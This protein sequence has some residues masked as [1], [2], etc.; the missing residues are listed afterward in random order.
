[1]EFNE[2]K[3]DWSIY[4]S[5]ETTEAFWGVSLQF[6][7]VIE[8]LNYIEWTENR[9]Q[10]LSRYIKM[11]GL[12]LS[13]TVRHIRMDS[14]PWEELC[15]YHLQHHSSY[16]TEMSSRLSDRYPTVLTN[17]FCIYL[18]I[19]YMPHE[20][21][22]LLNTHLSGCNLVKLQCIGM[23]CSFQYLQN[24]AVQRLKRQNAS[25]Q[26]EI[27]RDGSC[28]QTESFSTL[29][30]PQEQL[31]CNCFHVRVM[32]FRDYG[33]MT[34]IYAHIYTGTTGCKS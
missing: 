1:M 4:R 18:R 19:H 32:T 16:G 15:L 21:A 8:R 9:P 6:Q 20:K 17:A 24:Y 23:L 10:K 7:A 34:L 12:Y 14:N 31:N 2:K 5:M 27:E 25:N 13:R 30:I 22:H 28:S 26:H 33:F 3:E 29:L 11:W